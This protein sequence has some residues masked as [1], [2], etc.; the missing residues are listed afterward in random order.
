M[1]AYELK[2]IVNK[3]HNTL[4]QTLRAATIVDAITKLSQPYKMLGCQIEIISVGR[5]V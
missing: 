3:C 4:T 2:F 5:V 1:N